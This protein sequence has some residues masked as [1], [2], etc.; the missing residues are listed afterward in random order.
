MPVEVIMPKVDMDMASG[1]IVCWHVAEG[2]SVEKGA[3]L[4]DIE[5]DKAAMEVEAPA[6]GV[7]RHPVVEG[8]V[9]AI[10][11]AVA[12]LYAEGE[13]IGALPS[14][15]AA[16]AE[17]PAS[18]AGPSAQ[19]SVKPFEVIMPKVDMDM[20][21]G[22]LACWHVSEGEAV[23]RGAPL[24][25][26]E[27]DK[28]AMEVEAPTSG[29]LGHPVAEGSVIAIGEAVAWLY[30]EGAVIGNVPPR[31]ITAPER[32]ATTP[33]AKKAVA[34]TPHTEPGDVAQ[35]DAE[36][37]RATPLARSLA[38]TNG[39]EL[40]AVRGSGVRGRIQ[41]ADVRALLEREGPPAS[42]PGFVPET[43]VLAVS[44]LRGGSGTPVVLLHGFASD[45]ASWA[46]LEAQ[47]VGRPVIRIEL[48]AHGRSPK[49]R[50]SSFS[51]LVAEVR[52]AFDGLNL[53]AVHLVGHSLGGAL[54][55]ALADTRPRK[56]RSLTLIA[57][58]GL[59]PQINGAVL[60]GIC[61]AT[62]SESLAPWLRCLVADEDRITD[63]YVRQVMATRRDPAL[64]AAQTA[65]AAALFPDGVQAF[66]LRA[67]L[68]RIEP[69]TAIVW[70]RQDAIIP[71]RHALR[72]PGRIALHLFDGA[73]HVPQ[74]EL[75]EAV[76]A[77]LRRMMD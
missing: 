22:K 47:L 34:T 61:S 50:V 25:D 23:E 6:S 70:G 55:L 74:F 13:A 29:V 72:A 44:R 32:P 57:P 28:A 67:A 58:G 14:P 16:A 75:P 64:R 3:P 20:A 33:V 59:G 62:Q 43:G 48:P 37:I 26:I 8:S 24:F 68:D 53:D 31:P 12:W 39:I 18:G 2:E 15:V 56:V 52:N 66:D 36:R 73:G 60:S 51:D 7:L 71:W 38:R 19:T 5:T 1:K 21:S 77:V 65:L 76:A 69:P 45:G 9:V 4:F 41:A 40:S 27:T 46:P 17:E 10:G 11:E 30:P 42:A 49:L 54:A 35:A 63:A